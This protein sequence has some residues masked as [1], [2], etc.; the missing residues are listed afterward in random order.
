M[1]SKKKTVTDIAP[2]EEIFA[3]LKIELSELKPEVREKAIELIHEMMNKGIHKDQ[4]ISK[5][6]Q[7]AETWFLESQG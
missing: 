7:E 2:E 1:K 3:N 5:A 4:A 6:I